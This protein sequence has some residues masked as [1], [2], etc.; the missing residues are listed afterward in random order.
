MRRS[1]RASTTAHRRCSSDDRPRPRGAVD[2]DARF[3]LERSCAQAG[4]SAVRPSARRGICRLPRARRIG[5]GR[6]GHRSRWQED[7][8]AAGARPRRRLV[9]PRPAS[10]K[11]SR[12]S[13]VA[14]SSSTKQGFY[15]VREAG[16]AGSSTAVAASN[17]ELVESD[18]TAVDPAEISACGDRRYERRGGRPRRHR[19]ARRGAGAL[20]T[21]LVVLA[22][23]RYSAT[24]GRIPARTS[25]FAGRS[26]GLGG[27]HAGS[28]HERHAPLGA[29]GRH[30]PG[31]KALAHEAGA[32]RRRRVSREHRGRARGLGLRARGAALQSRLDSR[33][34]HRPWSLPSSRPRPGSSCARSCAR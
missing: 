25:T 27:T 11:T 14:C 23:R 13:R 10:A 32:A 4:V 3:V 33:L 16:P 17:V 7:A 1:S 12:G 5:H 19:L 24:N 30:S 26:N 2:V 20:T 18:R 22:V 21:S 29:H 8:T 34:P 15:E 31:A 9:S 6:S 28:R